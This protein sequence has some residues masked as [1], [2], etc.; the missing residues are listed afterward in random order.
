M[1]FSP[2]GF[3]PGVFDHVAVLGK[4]AGGAEHRRDA[5]PHAGLRQQVEPAGMRHRQV[6]ERGDAGQQQLGQRDAHAMR[7]GLGVGAEDRQVFVERGIVEAGRADLVDQALVHRLAGRVGVD[8]DQARHDHQAGAV[9]GGVGGACVVAADEDQR[10]AVE[11][12]V[13]VGEIDVRLRAGVPGDHH[14]GVADEGGHA[15]IVTSPFHSGGCVA[16]DDRAAR[17]ALKL[18]TRRQCENHGGP[19]RKF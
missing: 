4:P 3:V 19:R 14:S 10:A 1:A 5:D 8:V 17:L 6:G 15:I 13:G 12:H 16:R 2:A 11:C 7:D 9:D 18:L